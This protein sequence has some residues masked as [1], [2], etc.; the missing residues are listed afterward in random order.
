[1]VTPWARGRGRPAGVARPRDDRARRRAAPDRRD[2]RRRHRR[3]SSSC[4]TTGSTSSCTS[5]PRRWREMDDF[6][7][8]MHTKSGLLPEIEGSSLSL[9]AAGVQ[10][11]EYLARFVPAAEARRRCAATRSASTAASSTGSCPTLDEYLH[12]RSIDVSSLKELCRRWYPDVYRKRPGKAEAHRALADIRESIAELRYYREAMLRPPETPAVAGPVV[13]VNRIGDYA[14]IGDCHSRRSSGVTARVDWA[15]FPR[16]DSPSVF[17][18]MLDEQRGGHFLV[19]PADG[20]SAT[21]RAYVDGHQRARHHVHDG[22]PAPS[23]SPTACR[24]SRSIPRTPRRCGPT[25]RSCAACAAPTARSRCAIELRPRFE[26]G[27]WSSPGSGCCHADDGRGRRRRRR[28]SGCDRP[29]RSPTSD[30][31]IGARWALSAGDEAWIEV[32]WCSVA[33]ARA[34]RDRGAVRGRPALPAR[35]HR[36][37]LAEWIGRCRYDGDVRRRRAP[38]RA[39]AEGADVR[40]HGRGHRR[41][42]RRRSPSGSAAPATGTTAT[43]GSATP[44]SRSCRCSCSAYDDEA[45]AFKRWLERTGAGRPE[46]LQIMYGIGGERMLPELELA[47]LAGHRDSRPGPHR[48]RRGQAAAARLRTGSSS[49]PRTSTDKAGGELTRDELDVPRR[50]RRHRGA[51]TGAEP[52]HGIWEMRDEPRHFLHSKL[53]CWVAL[54]RAVSIADG[55]RAVRRRRGVGPRARPASTTTCSRRARRTAGSARPRASTLPTP[56]TLLVPALGFLPSDRSARA[57]DD[58]RSSSATSRT[59]ASCTGTSSPDGLDGQRGRVP[60][61]LVLAARLPHPLGPPRRGRPRCSSGSSASPTTSACSPRRSTPRPARQL[62]N[63]PRRSRT[64]RWWPRARTWRQPAG[65]T[66]RPTAVPTPTPSSRSTGCWRRGAI[67]S[68]GSPETWGL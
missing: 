62:G 35:A 2:R 9:D 16:F 58:R 61:L 56:S 26:Y 64:W 14:M 48:Q 38:L 43:R 12:Y 15:C 39:R 27:A 29:S 1:M 40:A 54:D 46:D 60:A 49:R 66:S 59:T 42:G 50:A 25:T 30:E 11:L 13:T 41:R 6:V 53:N 52:D 24:S 22:R 34:R 36:R 5:R 10:V 44:P 32:G 3:A 18:R 45:D 55:A 37:L 7:R 20:A 68:T 23:R 8:T 67:S 19:T 28:R 31:A 21:S 17:A 47:H 57:G 63:F 33:R 4:S 65:A 51:A